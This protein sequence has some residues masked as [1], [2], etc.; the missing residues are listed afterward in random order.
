M[1][2]GRASGL[3][4]DYLRTDLRSLGRG[5][6]SWR[7]RRSCRADEGLCGLR[8]VQ[9][10]LCSCLT[11]D[12]PVRAVCSLETSG[13]G[14]MIYV[15][16]DLGKW[17]VTEG[18]GVATWGRNICSLLPIQIRVILPDS[19]FCNAGLD[20]GM[21]TSATTHLIIFSCPSS[22]PLITPPIFSF[23]NLYS[24]K[25]ISHIIS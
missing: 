18:R 22:K 23:P 15:A 4:E 12:L 5:E 7:R 16:C 14:M 10:F 17:V 8:T 11:G 13:R 9:Q 2:G 1:E 19:S 24:C 25:C 20:W 6:S 21:Q 3:P